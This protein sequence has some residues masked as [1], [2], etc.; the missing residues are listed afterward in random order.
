[1]SV[2]AYPPTPPKQHQ[3]NRLAR[4]KNLKKVKIAVI[5]IYE[6]EKSYVAS[7]RQLCDY[8]A[9]PLSKTSN[10]LHSNILTND[11]HAGIFSNVYQIYLLNSQ[12]LDAMA[13][14]AGLHV[15][16]Q[17]ST[18]PIAASASSSS[19]SSTSSSSTSST[20]STTTTTTPA[21]ISTLNEAAAPQASS[22][23]PSHRRQQSITTP[24]ETV[25]DIFHSFTPFLKMYVFCLFSGCV[26]ETYI[27]I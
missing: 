18:T 11:E 3:I 19:S 20:S 21:T 17:S 4:E 16:M 10:T 24:L 22:H 2:T 23:R 7:L 26:L 5:E 13:P 14:L 9:V 12:L 15:D 27:K 1:M 8:Y 25:Y 6:S